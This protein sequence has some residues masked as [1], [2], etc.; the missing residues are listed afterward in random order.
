MTIARW[1]RHQ[2]FCFARASVET[3]RYSVHHHIKQGEA[4]NTHIKA[5]ATNECTSILLE[6]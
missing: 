2:M 4:E 3:Q 6:K 1:R 5:A